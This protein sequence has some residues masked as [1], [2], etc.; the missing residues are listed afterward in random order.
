MQVPEPVSP[1][2]RNRVRKVSCRW[3]SHSGKHEPEFHTQTV[4]AFER[5]PFNEAELAAAAFLA[6]YS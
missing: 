2:Y 5:S 4:Q 1:R 3:R 6:R